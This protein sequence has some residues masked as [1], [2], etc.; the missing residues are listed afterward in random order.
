[1]KRIAEIGRKARKREAGCHR[2]SLPETAMFRLKAI[3]GAKLKSRKLAAQKTEAA[4][5]IHCLDKFTAPGMTVSK[6]V[7]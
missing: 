7:N 3:I 2:R 4:T 6:K 5:G 1:M